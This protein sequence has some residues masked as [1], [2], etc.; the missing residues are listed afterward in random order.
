MSVA[1]I[2]GGSRGLGREAARALT[3]AGLTVAITGRDA[4]ALDAVV[5]AGEAALA[6]PGDATVPAAVTEAVRRTQDELGPVDLLLASAGAFATGGRLWESDP[7]DWWRDVTVN[8]RGP[9]LALHAVLPSMVGRGSGRIVLMGSGFG[10]RPTPGASAYAASKAAL[11]RLVDTVAG[12][13]GGTGVTLLAVSPGMVPTDMTQAFPEGFLQ[14]RP[15]LRD[16]EPERWSSV[17]GFTGLLL[18]IAAG[19]LDVL[20]G[21]FVRPSDDLHA[22]RAAA[23]RPEPGTLRLVPWG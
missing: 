2:T 18:Q 10:M 13:L 6:L 7:D 22:A 23:E 9:A 19:E 21:R 20:S 8:L 5:A 17:E 3:R 14:F 12:E 4:E 11:A 16:P 15:D 1:L